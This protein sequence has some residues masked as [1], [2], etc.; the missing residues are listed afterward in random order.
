VCEQELEGA[1]K[2]AGNAGGVFGAA[3]G[4]DH[5]VPGVRVR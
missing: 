1:D 3:Q 2:G 5:H 4:H